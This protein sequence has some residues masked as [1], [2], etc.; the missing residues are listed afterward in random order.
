MKGRG[1]SSGLFLWRGESENHVPVDGG[2]PW[3]RGSFG[4]MLMNREVPD[5]GNDGNEPDGF[6]GQLDALCYLPLA[7]SRNAVAFSVFW[8]DD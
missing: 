1:E 4:R 8:P 6:Q 7:F 5:S 2:I 3:W